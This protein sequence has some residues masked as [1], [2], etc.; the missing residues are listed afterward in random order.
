M[1]RPKVTQS[2]KEQTKGGFGKIFSTL[3]VLPSTEEELKRFLKEI[4]QR[5]KKRESLR[6]SARG[7]GLTR[8]Q[9]I[10]LAIA[11]QRQRA[12]GLGRV[13]LRRR[14]PKERKELINKIRAAILKFFGF[15]KRGK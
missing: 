10:R 9:Q 2:I 1:A 6:R 3:T 7:G 13:S 11:R 4:D 5:N 15:K 12:R 14:T 8:G